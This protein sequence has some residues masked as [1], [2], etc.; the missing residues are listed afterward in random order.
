MVL[1]VPS[2]P[3]LRNRS[4]VALLFTAYGEERSSQWAGEEG[5]KVVM[6]LWRPKLDPLTLAD[7][8]IVTGLTQRSNRRLWESVSVCSTTM[9]WP[10]LSLGIREERIK[11]DL[12]LSP[13]HT[14]TNTHLKVCHLY[15]LCP[16]SL[17]C[18]LSCG[19]AVILSGVVVLWN[20]RRTWGCIPAV[21]RALV[22]TV[23][24][25]TAFHCGSTNSYHHKKQ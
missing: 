10:R 24:W 8:W 11:W 18:C 6:W 15:L 7:W 25:F 9:E 5:R 21:W 3:W 13:P 23:I 4:R 2:P 12:G 22:G 16:G 17:V 19:T 1:G 20:N 14:H